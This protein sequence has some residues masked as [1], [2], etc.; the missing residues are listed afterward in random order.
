MNLFKNKNIERKIGPKFGKKIQ[1]NFIEVAKYFEDRNYKSVFFIGPEDHWL[2]SKIKKSFP[3]ALY[4]EE[5]IKEFSGPEIVMS[6]TKYLS[7]ALAND[8]GVGHMLSTQY[9]NLFKL[10][11]HHDAVKFTPPSSNIF[12]ISSQDFGSKDINFIQSRDVIILIEKKL[13]I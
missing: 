4:P 8:S 2:I 5:I 11:G 13:T 10:F 7:C 3:H 1:K 6:C 9:C 12:T